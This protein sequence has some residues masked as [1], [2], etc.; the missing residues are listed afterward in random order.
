[1]TNEIII[2]KHTYFESWDTL[3]G[4]FVHTSLINI[5]PPSKGEEHGLAIGNSLAEHTIANSDIDPET[6]IGKQTF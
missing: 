3:T 4:R 5:V 1:M 2:P 6:P